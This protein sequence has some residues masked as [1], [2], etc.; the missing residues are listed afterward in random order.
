MT[1]YLDMSW[2]GLQSAEDPI[3][4]YMTIDEYM[5]SSFSPDIDFVDGKVENRNVGEWL[6]S[7]ALTQAMCLLGN[8]EKAWGVEVLPICRLRV[9]ESRI[10]VPDV[11]VISPNHSREQIVSQV[12]IVCIEVISPDDTWRRLRSL[13]TDYWTMGVQNI[14]AFEPE[15]RLVHR[16]DGDGLHRVR[17]AEL[18][19]SGT[20]IRLDV[21]EVFD[22]M[23]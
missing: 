19:V 23:D 1:E 12:P 7:R 17:E 21:A 5:H 14:W 13:F 2:H 9:S 20:E 16:F 6:H 15:E 3:P 22:G 11:M 10:R 18:R 4:L 8:H